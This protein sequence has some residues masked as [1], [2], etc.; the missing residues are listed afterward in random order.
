MGSSFGTKTPDPQT[1]HD[2]KQNSSPDSFNINLDTNISDQITSRLIQLSGRIPAVRVTPHAPHEQNTTLPTLRT[3]S[4][5]MAFNKP[6]R[7]PSSI[8]M[9]AN[10][11]GAFCH[12]NPQQCHYP[13]SRK[14]LSQPGK[15]SSAHLQPK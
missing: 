8:S 3:A 2:V 12:Q 11:S 15:P 5:H 7:F 1:S 9:A 4:G 10:P 14:N 6:A 13:S